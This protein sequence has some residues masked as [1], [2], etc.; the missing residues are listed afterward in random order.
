MKTYHTT[1]TEAPAFETRRPMARPSVHASVLV[2]LLQ[3]LVIAL[4]GGAVTGLMADAIGLL[5]LWP[6]SAVLSLIIFCVAFLSRMA[7]SD[8]TLWQIETILGTDLDRDGEVGQPE[9][10]FVSINARPQ[11]TPEEQLRA[12]FAGF[13]RGCEIRTDGR[14]W[15]TRLGRRYL[16][17]RD[18]LIRNG[19]AKWNVP[20]SPKQG[21][22]LIASANDILEHVSA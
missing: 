18:I 20:G 10:H 2:P 9:A 13:V 6:G 16:E 15:E 11:L 1:A 5:S 21:W 22:A 14:Y 19:W 3:S 17:F 4:A 7:A 12:D 8:R